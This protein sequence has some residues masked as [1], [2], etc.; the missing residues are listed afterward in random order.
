MPKAKAIE[1]TAIPNNVALKMSFF[2]LIV[3]FSLTPFGKGESIATNDT[4]SSEN[5]TNVITS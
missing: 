5:F 3:Y 2:S 4:K 1:S